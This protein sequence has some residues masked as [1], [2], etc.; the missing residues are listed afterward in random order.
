MICIYIIYFLKKMTSFH[1][2][3]K[4]FFTFFYLIVIIIPSFS[5]IKLPLSSNSI[6]Q[7]N[8]KLRSLLYQNTDSAD[9]IYHILTTELC[10]GNPP[11]CFKFAYDT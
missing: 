11:Q 5:N 7:K 9:N 6:S 1:F 8:H 10:L 2:F 3:Q 4:Y